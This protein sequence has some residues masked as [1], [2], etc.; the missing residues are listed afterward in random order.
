MPLRVSATSNN[1]LVTAPSSGSSSIRNLSIAAL[2]TIIVAANAVFMIWLWLK[3]GGIT[4]ATGDGAIATSIGRITGL[5]GAYLALIQVLLIARLPPLE[6]LIGFDR[7]TVWHR[8]NGR[9][10]ITLVIAHVILTTI[11][12]QRADQLGLSDEIS[13]LLSDYPGMIVATIGT[14]MMLLVVASSV[15]MVRRRLPYELWYWVHV[16]AYAAIALAYVH[17]IPTGNELTTDHLANTYWKGLYIGSLAMVVIF[18]LA[19]PAVSNLRH[20][21]VVEDLVEEG[22]GVVSVVIGGRSL[23]RIGARAGQ[24]MRWR[25]LANG[26]WWQTHPFSLSAAPTQDRLRITVK[27][28]GTYT[29]RI[30]S[31]K[32]GTRILFEGPFG[33]FVGSRRRHQGAVMIAGG[34]GITPVRSLLEEFT[35]VSPLTVIYRTIKSEDLVLLDE[36]KHLAARTGA[37]VH[38]VTGDHRDSPEGSGELLGPDHLKQLAPDLKNRDVFICGP[39]AMTAAVLQSLKRAGVPRRNIHHEQFAL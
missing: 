11:G 31:V 33:S 16:S 38:C 7:L 5:L 1:Q 26:L 32:P 25:F 9:A 8:W 10:C 21:L 20:R 17:Q 22:P 27:A 3:N 35:E 30:A 23:T 36:I 15:V 19:V 13:S 37:D 12:Y 4:D 28:V 2:L 6:H 29:S 14:A 34:I 24:F 18:R 39:P